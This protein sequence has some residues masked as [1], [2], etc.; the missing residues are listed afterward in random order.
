MWHSEGDVI[1]FLFAE[2]GQRLCQ[3]SNQ[4][5]AEPALGVVTWLWR[6][7][8]QANAGKDA[9]IVADRTCQT[10]ALRNNAEVNH[11]FGRLSVGPAMLS[12]IVQQFRQ[13]EFGPP[14]QV[15]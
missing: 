4:E 15:R 14:H 6:L 8:V 7:R 11:R 12:D 9:A 3:V 5:P 10:V 2:I 13:H 1:S